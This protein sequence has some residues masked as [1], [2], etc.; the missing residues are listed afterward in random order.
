MFDA[1]KGRLTILLIFPDKSH[2]STFTIAN[3]VVYCILCRVRYPLVCSNEE[4]KYRVSLIYK[5][6][7]P[8]DQL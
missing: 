2:Y 7:S 8:R 5:R 1:T 4:N 6:I 3:Q